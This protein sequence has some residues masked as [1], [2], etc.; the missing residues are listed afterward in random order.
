MRNED[1]TV[2]NYFICLKE[3]SLNVQ[4]PLRRYN[5]FTLEDRNILYSLIDDP[6]SVLKISDEGLFE[7]VW[8]RV[9]YLN[10]VYKQ[11]ED[12]GKTIKSSKR[13]KF[14]R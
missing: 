9:N 14:F 2:E 12:G 11:R 1:T 8:D 6:T 4:T 7:V 5:N 3:K 13:L 10:K